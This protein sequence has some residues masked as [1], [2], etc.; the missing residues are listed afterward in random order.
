MRDLCFIKYNDALGHIKEGDVLLFR[1]PKS[2]VSGLI[3]AYGDSLYSHV[4]LASWVYSRMGMPETLE[5]LEFKEWIGSRAVNLRNY[6]KQFN[7]HIDVFAPAPYFMKSVWDCET[8]SR[9]QE[10]IFFR[11]KLL[12][13]ELRGL[14]GLPYGWS[15]IWTMAVR[16]FF[17][18]RLLFANPADYDD[19][20]EDEP[21]PVCSSIISWCFSKHFVDLVPQFDDRLVSPGRVASSSL[22]T[23]QFTLTSG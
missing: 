17:S 23:Y 13:N 2:W 7:G 12:T 9:K 20:L 6:V 19:K 1:K 22:L 21:Y 15:R 18:Y 5:C 16:G 10:K 14:T 4:G 3:R 8:Q 11:G